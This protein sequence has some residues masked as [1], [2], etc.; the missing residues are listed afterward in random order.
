MQWYL[1][2]NVRTKNSGIRLIE[3]SKALRERKRMQQE[4]VK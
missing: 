2:L 3:Q 1:N 4:K